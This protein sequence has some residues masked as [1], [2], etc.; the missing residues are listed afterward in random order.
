MRH[1][2]KSIFTIMVTSS[3]FFLGFY[4][5]KE[6]IMSMIPDFQEDSDEKP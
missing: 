2:L 1:I 5:G 3:A 6:K 4:L